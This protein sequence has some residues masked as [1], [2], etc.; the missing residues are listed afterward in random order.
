MRWLGASIFVGV[1]VACTTTAKPRLPEARLEPAMSPVMPTG[2]DSSVGADASAPADDLPDVRSWSEDWPKGWSDPRVLAALTISCD[3]A[4]ERPPPKGIPPEDRPPNV[5]TCDPGYSQACVVD[6]CFA[7]SGNCE[8][9]CKGTCA[10]CNQT[11][12]GGCDACKAQCA[13]DGCKKACAV[14]CA[15]CKQSCVRK[16]DRCMTGDCTKIH[17]ACA[18]KMLA[19]WRSGGCASRCAKSLRCHDACDKAK[20]PEGCNQHCDDVW[21]PGYRACTEKCAPEHT[22]CELECIETNPCSPT[23]CMTNP[24]SLYAPQTP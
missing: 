5:L 16:M 15:D 8:H 22:L 18:R 7:D 10:S 4:P 14:T 12:A 19:A 2:A 24:P 6:A 11:C 9:A 3:F 23:M 13:D 21:A 17:Q 20:D 1:T